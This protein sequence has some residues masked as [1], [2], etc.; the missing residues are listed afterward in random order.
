MVDRVPTTAPGSA[1]L[2]T[3]GAE[4]VMSVGA[5]FTPVTVNA[6]SNVRPPLSVVRTVTDSVGV[7]SKSTAPDPTC[8][9]SSA[10]WNAATRVLVNVACDG[11]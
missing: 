6:L 2:S 3:V 8:N 10:I 9:L 4:K 7:A 5:S 1:L 11:D